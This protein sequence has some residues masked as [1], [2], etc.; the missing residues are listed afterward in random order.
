[1]TTYRLILGD[2]AERLR[3]L[4]DCS[5]DALVTDPPAGIGFMGRAWDKNKGGRDQWVAWLSG[6]MSEALRVLKPGAHGLVWA[7]PR[8]SHWTGMALE[9][10]GFEIRDRLAHLFS[11]GF[12]KSLDVGKAIDAAAGVERE[13]VGHKGGRYN[14]PGTDIKGGRLI[15]G[16]PGKLLGLGNIT[17]PATEAAKKWEGWGTALKPSVEDWWLVRKPFPG[18]V[19]ANVL[20]YGTG[21]LNIDGCRVAS[22]KDHAEKCAS[23]V[24]LDS[25]R[26]GNCYGEMTGQREDSYSAAGRWPPHLLLSHAEGCKCLFSGDAGPEDWRCVEGCA[27]LE[28]GRQSGESTSIGGRIGNKDGGIAV[29]CGRYEAG[30]PGFGDTGTAA[31]F[32]P[33]FHYAPK[34][35]RAERDAG[36]VRAA[37]RTAGEATGRA[38]GSAGLDSPRAGAGRTSGARN[39]HP[40]VKALDLMRWLVRLI[41]PP[42]GIVLDPFM[43]SGSTG[44][45]ALMEEFS[46]IGI[47]AEAEYMALAEQRIRRWAPMWATE[48]QS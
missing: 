41:T 22:G 24:G 16:D 33:Q 21:A 35:C 34:P 20:E 37:H 17:A 42:G 44:C 23:V 5:V 38:D 10:A 7:L 36:I 40:T 46:F 1:M 48:M 6:V 32:F 26:N 25:N 28:L 45:A 4:P 18:T 19:A 9:E 13:V 43:G 30:D 2:C 14:S 31:R 15:G 39:H 11:T 3:E 29:P 47:E 8:T 12:P 27:V